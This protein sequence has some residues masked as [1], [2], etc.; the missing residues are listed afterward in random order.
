MS[1][2]IY[3]CNEFW[4]AYALSLTEYNFKKCIWHNK[5]ENSVSFFLERISQQTNSCDKFLMVSADIFSRIKSCFQANSRG[6]NIQNLLSIFSFSFLLLALFLP[7]RVSRQYFFEITVEWD[8]FGWQIHC[9]WAFGRL[10]I[11]LSSCM[12]LIV[13]VL[14]A[15]TVSGCSSVSVMG[16]VVVL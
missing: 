1:W 13:Q 16:R 11:C 5:C 3:F 12:Y 15:S 14:P 6:W 4:A 9:S 7:P 2:D 10:F 8:S